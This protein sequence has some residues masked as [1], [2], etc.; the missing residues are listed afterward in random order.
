[1]GMKDDEKGILQSIFE[2]VKEGI[3]ILDLEGRITAANSRARMLVGGND[4]I[5]GKN[6]AELEMFSPDTIELFLGLFRDRLENSRSES[7]E[8]LI[9]F[10]DG[11]VRW[12][13]LFS[14]DL[15]DEGGRKIGL[16]A[17]IDD[18]T[19]RKNDERSVSESEEKYRATVEQSAEN[20][21]IY[22]IETKRIVE[23]NQTLQ[24]LLG[25]NAEE[26][27]KLTPGDFIAD[28][29]V[30]SQ[31]EKVLREG[32]AIVGERTYIR[33][34]G[35]MVDVEVSASHI[36]Y[37][38]RSMLCVVSR[39]ITDRKRAHKQV[40]KER[41]MAEFYLD[42]LAHDIGNMHQ[43]MLTGLEM[44]TYMSMEKEKKERTMALVMN[45]LNRS[46]KLAKDVRK[47][48]RLR[49]TPVN[50]VDIDL[51]QLLEKSF[52]SAENSFPGRIVEHSFE[53]P[54]SPIIFK[55][56]P[57]LQEAFY[58]IYHNAMKYQK[59]E[60][61]RIETVIERSPSGRIHITIS[62]HGP[63]VP[64]DRKGGV[65]ERA[66]DPTR[67]QNTGIGMVI[68]REHVERNGGTIEVTDRITGNH[69]KGASFN[70][71]FSDIL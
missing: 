41:N 54:L 36:R 66:N 10:R 70:I 44:I 8:I 34:D 30:D 65:F 46:M 40:V 6:I 63:G 60:P 33:K 5:V 1:M 2:A 24:K 67:R 62:D 64:D 12:A 27:E 42:T 48:S 52:A 37:S 49:D 26:M 11:T 25:Y 43:G 50:K 14:N 7:T 18:I 71:K 31:V 38:N 23:S 61:A 28:R 45:L 56:E 32:K 9:R 17:M 15:T 22:D 21:Y 68:A 57:L 16:I 55:A 47:F 13:E 58:N 53:K 35:T 51:V 39:D 29:D 69:T 3:L 20:I 59:E 4:E 19:E